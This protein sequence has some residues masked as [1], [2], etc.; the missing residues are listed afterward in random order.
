MNRRRSGEV[1]HYGRGRGQNANEGGRTS[2][3]GKTDNIYSKRLSYEEVRDLLKRRLGRYKKG[4]IPREDRLRMALE[5]AKETEL[6]DIDR[7]ILEIEASMIAERYVQY[8]V[9]TLGK[10]P[11]DRPEGVFRWMY[12]QVNGTS[13]S[14]LR[15][16]KSSE[17]L[18][19]VN[20]YSV[21]GG[22]PR[23]TWYQLQHKPVVQKTS[24]LVQSRQTGD[25]KRIVEQTPRQK[26]RQPPARKNRTLSLR[27]TAVI[28]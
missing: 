24:G 2:K 1:T 19:L 5:Y 15:K 7:R 21:Q 27:I 6:E 11:D 18:H 8:N 26:G 12:C 4:L 20:K 14:D 17:I 16:V 25:T 22:N 9:P 3:E 23:G 13:Q 28:Y 10:V